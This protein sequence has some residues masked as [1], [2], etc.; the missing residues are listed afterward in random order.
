MMALWDELKG[1]AGSITDAWIV[2]GD[3]NS[4]FE[5]EDRVGGAQVTSSE[6]ADFQD[7]V[8]TAQLQKLHYRGWKYT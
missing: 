1:L 5:I 2:I 3:F 8:A 7:A 4:I 6:C